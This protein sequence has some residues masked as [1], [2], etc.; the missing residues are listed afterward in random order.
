MSA[1]IWVAKN[2]GPKFLNRE[3]GR[4]QIITPFVTGRQTNNTFSQGTIT[5]SSFI[6]GA[7]HQAPVLISSVA[8]AFMMEEGQLEV[9][10][11][12]YD[13]VSLIDGDV[14]FIPTST[15]FSYTATAEFTKFMYVTG[16]GRV[17]TTS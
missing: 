2:Y 16:E 14:V 12:G 3:D 17:W 11:D 4:Y 15:S 5:L 6:D 7:E 13:P 1:P 9:T 10:V 8:T